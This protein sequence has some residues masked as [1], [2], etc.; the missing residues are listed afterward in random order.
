VSPLPPEW[1]PPGLR[2]LA[3]EER[4]AGQP[5][6]LAV[7]GPERAAPGTGPTVPVTAGELQVI[8]TAMLDGIYYRE[9]DSDCAACR[10]SGSVCGDHED[11][12]GRAADYEQVRSRL[13]ERA[14]LAGI[15]LD[16]E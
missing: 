4:A 7:F 15:M 11:D 12:A 5:D 13:M 3:A 9:P 14:R 8:M 2:Q 16:V 10:E 6:P 1:R